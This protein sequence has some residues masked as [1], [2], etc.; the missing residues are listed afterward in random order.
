MIDEARAE[1]GISDD[2]HPAGRSCPSRPIRVTV[3]FLKTK[4]S[5]AGCRDGGGR[6]GHMR[7]LY[8]K[9]KIKITRVVFL[10]HLGFVSDLF[11]VLAKRLRAG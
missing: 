10:L 8:A 2:A 7:T 3:P 6:G 1:V 11:R 5:A 4:R 9:K